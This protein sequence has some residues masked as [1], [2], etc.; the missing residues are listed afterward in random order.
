VEER[1]ELGKKNPQKRKKKKRRRKE[2]ERERERG[3]KFGQIWGR[4]R[5]TTSGRKTEVLQEGRYICGSSLVIK[6]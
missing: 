3:S 5:T 6:L 1:L 2:R 4:T